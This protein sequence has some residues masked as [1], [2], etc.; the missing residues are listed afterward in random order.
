[1]GWSLRHSRASR[2]TGIG[3][4]IKGNSGSFDFAALRMTAFLVVAA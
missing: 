4:K 1:M 3:D 2:C